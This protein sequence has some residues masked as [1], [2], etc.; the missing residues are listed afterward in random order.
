MSVLEQVITIIIAMLLG[1]FVELAVIVCYYQSGDYYANTNIAIFNQDNLGVVAGK[2]LKSTEGLVIQALNEQGFAIIN[3]GR[4]RLDSRHFNELV[5]EI[6]GLAKSTKIRL[7]WTTRKH[8]RRLN[9]VELIHAGASKGHLK[10]VDTEGWQGLIGAIGLRIED[11]LTEALIIR[12]LKLKTATPNIKQ[13]VLE[14]WNEWSYFQKWDERSINF[15]ADGSRKNMLYRP[16]PAVVFWSLL[17]F[18]LY[19]TIIFIKRRQ[20][21]WQ[22]I[23]IFF[24]AG[25]LMLDMRWQWNLWRQ[26]KITY[27]T[28]AGKTEEEKKLVGED[29]ELFLFAQEVKRRLPK[30]P[31]RI[32]VISSSPNSNSRYIR[33]RAHYHLLPHNVVSGFAFLPSPDQ[34]GQQDYLII[35]NPIKGVQYSQE[36]HLLTMHKEKYSLN[37]QLLYSTQAGYFFRINS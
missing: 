25:W 7:I 22:S 27:D 10:L 14:L 4:F 19:C 33:L 13:L 36:H 37:A 29:A 3:S 28:Y 17:S 9:Q 20:L 24:L 34:V 18:L 5:W 30:Q 35:L 21:V 12:Q 31:V 1:G 6:S 2:G 15:I 16:L 26:N 23:I 8:P 32:F 11:N